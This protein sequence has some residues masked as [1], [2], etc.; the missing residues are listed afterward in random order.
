MRM[1][2][3]INRSQH[4]SDKANSQFEQSQ[5]G[6]N[7]PNNEGQQQQ[8]DGDEKESPIVALEP[9]DNYRNNGTNFMGTNKVS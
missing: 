2:Q 6:D 8:N 3:R 4:N 5:R 9:E 1:S 7:Q